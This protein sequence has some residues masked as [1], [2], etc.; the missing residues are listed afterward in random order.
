MTT[1]EAEI[2]LM[3]MFD[4]RRN[5]IVPCITDMSF[6]VKFETDL[7]ILSESGYATGVEIKVS[8]ADLKNDLKKKHI[9]NLGTKTLIRGRTTKEWYYKNLKYFYYAVPN[10]LIEET[11]S[12][13]PNFAGIIDL[14][15]RKI[16]RKPKTL[17]TTKWTE[18]MRYSLARLGSMRILN[19]KRNLCYKEK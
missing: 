4:I 19:L 2:T 14:D 13:I 9:K 12:Q 10:K 17:F 11:K 1:L 6:L 7:L 3:E 15:K 18:K 16:V 5:L 8:K